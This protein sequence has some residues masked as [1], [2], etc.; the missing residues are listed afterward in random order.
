M[1]PTYLPWTGYFNLI[2]QSDVFVFLDDVQ[3]ERGS[4]QN[5]NRI[6]LNGQPHFLT[7]PSIR[8]QLSEQIKMVEID[9]KKNWRSKHV[10][11]IKQAYGKHPYADSLEVFQKFILDTSLTKLVDLNIEIISAVASCLGMK[12]NFFRSSELGLDGQRTKRLIL[13]SQHF[14]C[15]EYLSPIG[16]KSYLI[17]DSCFETAPVS[18]RFQDFTPTSYCQWNQSGFVSHLSIVDVIANLGWEKTSQYVRAVL[19]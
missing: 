12:K 6:L 2:F 19:M 14:G 13:I 3:Y 18:L 7:V 15:D 4:W 8:T 5:R 16:A 1:Q 17:E 11:T 9:A 10:K